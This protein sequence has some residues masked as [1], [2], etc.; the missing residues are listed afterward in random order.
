MNSAFTRDQLYYRHQL[1]HQQIDDWLGENR[2][3]QFPES[4]ARHLGKLNEFLDIARHFTQ[5]GIDFIPQ[6]GPIL[7]YRIYNDPL[8]RLYNDLDF[9]ISTENIR[10]A[11]DVLGQQ[12]YNTPF[13]NFP[14]DDCRRKILYKHVNELFLYNPEKDSGIELHWTLFTGSSENGTSF[15]QLIDSNN[16]KTSF[17]GQQFTVFTIEL[18]LLYLIIHG[19]LH[20]WEK[21]KWL[22]DIKELLLKYEMDETI[23]QKLAKRLSAFRMVA[24]CNELLKIF[25]PD[26]LLLPSPKTAPKPL[27]NFALQQ[28]KREN[29]DDKKSI[30]E[31]LKIFRFTLFAF[32]G[33]RFKIKTLKSM[34]FATD[35]VSKKWIPCS[36][37]VY[38]LVSPVWKLWRGFR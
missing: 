21:L 8:Y 17:Q 26:S 34:I 22:V 18:E 15:K 5:S 36:S 33:L 6:K 12:G 13:Y 4:K 14:S 29:I 20:G 24:V 16:T 23:F 3:V 7:S 1:S 32:P 19:G 11:I 10:K 25:F 27:V 37:L 35:L 9:L 31:Y 30:P 38:Y 28:I 2:C